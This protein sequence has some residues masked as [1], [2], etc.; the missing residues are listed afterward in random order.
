M[1]WTETHVLDERV[2][3]I[4]LVQSATLSF[5]ACCGQ[6]GVSRKTGYKW[7]RRYQA[8]GP[9]GLV[10]Q[11]RAPI[12]QAAATPEAARTL[13]LELRVR[14]D[15]GAR[16]L[17]VKLRE[18]YGIELAASTI[19]H[20]LHAAGLTHP[21]T[22]KPAGWAGPSPRTEATAPNAVW[23][24]DGKGWFRTGQGQRCE[25]LTVL[26]D[27]TRYALHCQAFTTLTHRGVQQALECCF[28]TYGLPAVIRTD[29]GAPF[30]S[31]A[32]TRL[33]RL[34]VWWLRLGI[35]S[36]R[37]PPGR[38]TANGRHE[39]FHRTLKDACCRP[40]AA[41]LR[42]QQRAF[43]QCLAIYNT[44]RP[45][46][47]LGQTPPAR[48]YTPSP[49]AYPAQLPDLI[50]PADCVF[51]KVRTD[52]TFRWRGTS[53]FLTEV[54]VGEWIGLRPTDDRWWTVYIGPRALCQWDALRC[55]LRPLGPPRGGPTDAP[56]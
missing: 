47:A 40:P 12:R 44:E 7:W 5:S 36:E 48:H 27:A 33:S 14:Y 56:L 35:A 29:N 42:A 18:D 43:D 1:S 53:V 45:H 9:P 21:R 11:P 54:L 50:Y 49:R 38:P 2:R 46:E 10:D 6:V 31:V 20:Y 30:A 39:R 23:T 8:L 4:A 15:W 55:V 32:W 19:G 51:R 16:K 28:R 52:G 37:I 13:L 22:G 24:L 41:T 25:P 34:Q 17:Q 26:D 3:F